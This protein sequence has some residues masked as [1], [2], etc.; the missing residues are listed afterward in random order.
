MTSY[1]SAIDPELPAIRDDFDTLRENGMKHIADMII[2][3]QTIVGTD[4]TDMTG[5]N[6]PT[7]EGGATKFGNLS[8]ML[9]A[10]SRF[11]TGEYSATYSTDS[12][13]EYLSNPVAQI[14][15]AQNRFLVPPMIFIQTITAPQSS[16]AGYR[17]AKFTAVNVSKTRFF[18]TSSTRLVSSSL[19]G[20][21]VAIKFQWIAIQPP[22]GFANED[23]TEG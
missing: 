6:S 9:V 16:V 15:F 12:A 14:D 18:V 17:Q 21:G 19:V 3:T 13:T 8:Q 2:A 20:S 11:E 5:L 4:F 7:G 1:P 10:L 23:L 22:F